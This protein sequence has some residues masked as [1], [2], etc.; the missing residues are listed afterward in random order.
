MSENKEEIQNDIFYIEYL[1]SEKNHKIDKKY[2]N[3]LIDAIK[4]GRENIER[5]AID[6]IKIN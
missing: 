4:W 6:S 3:S 1:N 2:F 5:F